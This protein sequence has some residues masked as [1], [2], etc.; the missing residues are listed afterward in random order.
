M[1]ALI[2]IIYLIFII[3]HDSP[4]FYL[5]SNDFKQATYY[6]IHQMYL[7]E[8]DDELAAEIASHIKPPTASETTNKISYMDSFFTDERY[9]RSSWVGCTLTSIVM[10]NGYL[11]VWTNSKSLFSLYLNESTFITPV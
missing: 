1:I 6:A 11:A 7:T 10:L 9:I 8:G 4:K 5:F 3:N 2:V